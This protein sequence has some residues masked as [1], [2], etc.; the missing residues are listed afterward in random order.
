MD[1]LDNFGFDPK[2]FI[3]QIINFVIIFFILKKIMYKPVMDMLKKRDTQIKKGLT[4]SQAAQN[5]LEKTQKEEVIIL[6]KAQEKAENIVNEARTQALEIKLE[7]EESTKK[8]AEKIIAQARET[9]K[10]EESD[11]ENKLTEK[12][13][14]IALSLLEK[15]LDGVFSKEEQQK[16]VKK[17]TIQLEKQL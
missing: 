11:A 8:E 1:I 17:A 15:S 3:A 10:Q 4:D 16:I 6:Q 7:T 13:G 14:Q 2:L 9:L 5:L 12:I